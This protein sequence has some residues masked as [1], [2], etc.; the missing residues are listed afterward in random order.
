MKS[1]IE[2]NAEIIRL[3]RNGMLLKEVA[4]QFG[5]S[6]Q[7]VDQIANPLPKDNPELPRE[8]RLQNLFPL[9]LSDRINLAASVTTWL[10]A[11]YVGKCS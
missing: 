9:T 11:K 2:R 6:T 4:A 10:K 3:R 5:I 7:R 1:F 8:Q